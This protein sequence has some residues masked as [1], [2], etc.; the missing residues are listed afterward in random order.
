MLAGT[1]ARETMLELARETGR[2]TAYLAAH[3]GAARSDTALRH[4]AALLDALL[5]GVERGEI[6]E[7]QAIGIGVVLV[8]AGGESTASLIGSAV[9]V[10]AERPELAQ[11]LR[12][13]PRRIPNFVE[14]VVRLESPFRG[15]Y[16][17]VR[18]PSELS[19]VQLVPGDRL[20]L[21]WA[22]ANRDAA[23]FER[24]RRDRPRAPPPARSSRLRARHPLLCGCAAR[25][26]RSARRAGG[27]AVANAASRARRGARAA[28]RAE[29][30]RAPPRGAAR[31]RRLNAP[32]APRSLP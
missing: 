17:V 29:P 20:F 24:A 26:P 25:A 15:H 10:L 2:L 6:S 3:F 7:A 1:I 31:P 16:R 11:A 18:R 28:A 27:A 30:L 8:G 19:G 12:H 23:R 9:R 5:G 22:S 21:L 14:E 32:R 13:E 4:A